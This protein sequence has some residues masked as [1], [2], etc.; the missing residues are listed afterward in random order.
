MKIKLLEGLQALLEQVPD[1]IN[2]YE[3]ND[4][5]FIPSVKR[6]LSAGEHLLTMHHK[7]QVAELA[8]AR[9]KII[10]AEQGMYEQAPAVHTRLPKRKTSAAIAIFSLKRAQEM[11]LHMLEPIM[12]NVEES[13]IL[14]KQVFALADQKSILTRYRTENPSVVNMLALWNYLASIEDIRVGLNRI[15]TLVSHAEA[16]QLMESALQEWPIYA[17]NQTA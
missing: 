10:A 9:G 17:F 15:L 1:L 6:W 11:L 13:K 14:M 8:G 4:P 7:P 3:A 2:K 16:L 5:A 12:E